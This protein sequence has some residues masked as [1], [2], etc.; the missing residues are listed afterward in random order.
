MNTCETNTKSLRWCQG[1][2]VV[3]GI[4]PR[5]YYVAKNDIVS[6]PTLADG[7]YVGDFVLAADKKWQ[8]IDILN[9]KS[10]VTSESQGEKPSKTFKNTLKVVY[11][12]LNE[13]LNAAA[14][15]LNSGDHVFIHRDGAG[16]F[17]VVGSELDQT[18]T[19]IS[20]DTGEGATGTSGATITATATDVTPAPFYDGS[21]MTDEGEVNPKGSGSASGSAAE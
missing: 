13:D 19:V 18:D 16:K 4:R 11:P 3:P 20:T 10:N 17:K 8:V 1:K 12:E 15:E 7:K 6:W 14:E 9:A 21:I 5:V 2:T